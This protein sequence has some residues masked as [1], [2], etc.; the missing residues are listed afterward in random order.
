MLEKTQVAEEVPKELANI[1]SKFKKH[2]AFEAELEA[3]SERVDAILAMGRNLIERGECNGSAEAMEDRMASIK[4]Q[5]QVGQNNLQLRAQKFCTF[6]LDV[7]L[8]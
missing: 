7:A 3:N 5:W 2:Q 4:E 1:Q 6:K 8:I